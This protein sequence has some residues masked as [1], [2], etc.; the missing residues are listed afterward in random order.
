MAE[1]IAF[2][3]GKISNFQGL[4]TWPWPWIRSYCIPSCITHL[5]LT[6]TCMPNFAEIKEILCEQTDV[7]TGIWDPLY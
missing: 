1:D 6:Y 2:E 3:N 4:V 7:Q 5:P